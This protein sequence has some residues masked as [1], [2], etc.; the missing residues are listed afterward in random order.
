MNKQLSAINSGDPRPPSLN[1]CLWFERVACFAWT[2]MTRW[3]WRERNNLLFWQGCFHSRLLLIHTEIS[4]QAIKN[5]GSY[6]P[7]QPEWRFYIKAMSWQGS[8]AVPGRYMKL[9]SQ[10]NYSNSFEPLHSKCL[11]TF[12]LFSEFSI[13][14][15]GL[16][17]SVVRC[18]I[19]SPKIG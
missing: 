9:Q 11:Y 4:F 1:T 19:I 5:P 17:D 10:Q 7:K 13:N 3:W 16:L 18:A 14:L 8:G 15:S 12:F 6:H 2:R